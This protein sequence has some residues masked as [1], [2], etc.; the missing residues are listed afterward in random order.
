M[1]VQ[2]VSAAVTGTIQP[3]LRTSI[4]EPVAAGRIEPVKAYRRK[5]S[6]IVKV[7]LV[8]VTFYLFWGAVGLVGAI[9]ISSGGHASTPT[10]VK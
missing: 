1:N 3:T 9:P 7:V 10:R 2:K 5:S 8:I 4:Y 6:L